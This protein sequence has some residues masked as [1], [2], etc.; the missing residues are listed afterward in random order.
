VKYKAGELINLTTG[1]YSD[2]CLRGTVKVLKDFDSLEAVTN[3]VS[4]YPTL[5]PIHRYRSKEVVEYRDTSSYLGIG[6]DDFIAWL[7]REG[8]IEDTPMQEWHV[9]SYSSIYVPQ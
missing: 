1:E 4:L 2:Y 5:K 7:N 3:F 9:G 8:Y 6:H